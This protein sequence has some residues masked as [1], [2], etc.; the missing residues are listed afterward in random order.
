VGKL[1]LYFSLVIPLSADSIYW[2]SPSASP[3]SLGLNSVLSL[4]DSGVAVGYAGGQAAEVSVS[5]PGDVVSLGVPAFFS[6]GVDINDNGQIAG[7]Y[8]DQNGYE[9]GFY[10]S[11]SSGT[12]PLGTLGGSMSIPTAIDSAG[13]IVGQSVDSSGNL[14]AFLWSQAAGMSK[15]GDGASEIATAISNS[16]EIAYQED[17]FPYGYSFAAVGGPSSVSML[18]FGGESSYITAMNDAGWIVGTVGGRGFLRTP[19]GIVD[20]GDAF[21]PVDINDSGEVLG[22]YQGR[23]AVWTASGGFQFLDLQGYT[24]ASATA[25]NDDGQIVGGGTAAPE[26]S[27]L[28]LFLAGILLMAAG[29]RRRVAAIVTRLGP[30]RPP[31]TVQGAPPEARQQGR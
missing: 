20:F 2:S 18:N 23:P 11:A 14:S 1:I 29:W 6:M 26:P 19:A 13:Q 9:Y 5:S 15:I 8:Q 27:A 25:I 3:A 4:N 22:S 28:G 24:S 30:S 7:M 31:A 21:R 17:P 16:G 12:V 10:W